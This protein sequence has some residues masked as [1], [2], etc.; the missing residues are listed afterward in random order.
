MLSTMLLPNGDIPCGV[1]DLTEEI[2][3][4][5]QFDIVV[6]KDV[7]PYIPKE[8]GQM[9]INNLAKLSDRFIVLSW[10]VP[11][12]MSELSHREISEEGIL[13]LMKKEQFVQERYMTANLLVLLNRKNCCVSFIML[14]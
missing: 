14:V 1:A 2:E 12:E 3:M 5:G 7:L 10:E 13:D 9:A 8:L 6:C 11:E 4:E